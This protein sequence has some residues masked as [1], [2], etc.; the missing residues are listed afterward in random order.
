MK[1]IIKLKYE[2]LGI[3]FKQLEV[4]YVSSTSI[5][6]EGEKLLGTVFIIISIKRIKLFG[7]IIRQ[8]F[9]NECNRGEILQVIKVLTLIFLVSYQIDTRSSYSQF[10]LD[11]VRMELVD[12]LDGHI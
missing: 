11:E 5:P 3:F 12:F 4:V 1:P 8:Y 10:E 2:K 7:E 9:Y 6:E